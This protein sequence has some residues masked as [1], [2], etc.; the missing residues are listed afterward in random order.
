MPLSRLLSSVRDLIDELYSKLNPFHHG[1]GNI[2]SV[3][4]RMDKT[5][6][7]LTS[8]S[9][10]FA[11]F[12]KIPNPERIEE[13]VDVEL[14]AS[15][16]IQLM[17]YSL[18]GKLWEDIRRRLHVPGRIH[19]DAIAVTEARRIT[20]V[21]YE[22]WDGYSHLFSTAPSAA[23][24]LKCSFHIPAGQSDLDDVSVL[25]VGD[26]VSD[27]CLYHS[28]SRLRGRVAWVPDSLIRSAM[29]KSC[30]RGVRQSTVYDN[31]VTIIHAALRL[32]EYQKY[33]PTP[34]SLVSSSLTKQTLASR[35]REILRLA[36][37]DATGNTLRRAKVASAVQ[38]I[39]RSTWRLYETDNDAFKMTEQFQN[40]NGINILTPPRPKHFGVV[41]PSGFAWVT[42]LHIDGYRLPARPQYGA[43]TVTH[44]NYTEAHVRVTAEGFGFHCPRIYSSP[45]DVDRTIVRPKIHIMPDVEVFRRLFNPVGFSANYSDKGN[46]QYVATGKF[47]SLAAISDFLRVEK[48]NTLLHEFTRPLP[49]KDTD[50]DGLGYRGRDRRFFRLVDFESI[51]GDVSDAGKC[52]EGLLAKGVIYRGLALQCERCRSRDWYAMSVITDQFIC[53]RCRTAQRYNRWNFRVPDEPFEPAWHYQLDELVL[54][55]ILHNNFTVPRSDA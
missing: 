49:K 10:P 30:D 16:P 39:R 52:V 55:S 26:S 41:P 40:G 36:Q 20:E 9:V 50:V 32:I 47:G 8:L 18:R 38:T 46:Y 6:F 37:I 13:F 4:A 24:M 34:V 12:A 19:F 51:F 33:H 2:P 25:V 11:G 23:S 29:A 21:L 35:N 27:F 22:L 17:V 5:P 15:L 44:L 45:G 54:P 31:E 43:S 42:E 1:A 3:T 48:N 7:I 53:S 14:N 28:L